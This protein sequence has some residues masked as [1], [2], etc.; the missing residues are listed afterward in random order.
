MTE[1]RRHFVEKDPRDIDSMVHAGDARRF[2][3]FDR[4]K[5]AAK[6]VGLTFKLVAFPV[7]D[8]RREQSQSHTEHQRRRQHSEPGLAL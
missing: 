4:V 1:T 5:A 6:I 2:S 7:V 8:G 3:A